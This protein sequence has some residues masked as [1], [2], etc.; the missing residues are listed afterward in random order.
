MKMWGEYNSVDAKWVL[1]GQHA[2][3]GPK[4]LFPCYFNV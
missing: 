1:D 2:F 3:N 4:D